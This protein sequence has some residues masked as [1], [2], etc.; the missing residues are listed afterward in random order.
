MAIE[1]TRI[2]KQVSQLLKNQQLIKPE[3]YDKLIKTIEHIALISGSREMKCCRDITSGYLHGDNGF[4]KDVAKAYP[5]LKKLAEAQDADPNDQMMMGLYAFQNPMCVQDEDPK[6]VSRKYLELAASKGQ[7]S[8]QF[9]V[10]LNFYDGLRGFERDY[11]KAVHYFNAFIKQETSLSQKEKAA[12]QLEFPRAKHMLALCTLNGYGCIKDEKLAIEMFSQLAMKE[13]F[14][15][16]YYELGKWFGSEKGGSNLKKAFVNYSLGAIKQDLK[17]KVMVA[18]CL[19]KGAGTEQNVDKGLSSLQELASQDAGAKNMLALHYLEGNYIPIDETL[20]FKLY[21]QNAMR[22]EGNAS[23]KACANVGRCYLFGIGVAKN[24]KQGLAYLEP[25]AKKGNT[26]AMMALG[27]YFKTHKA[28]DYALGAKYFQQAAE[29]GNEEGI[30]EYAYCLSKGMGVERDS[31]IAFELVQKLSDAGSLKAK[32]QLAQFYFNGIGT[33]RDMRIA[34][35]LFKEVINADHFGEYLSSWL[36]LMD[37]YEEGIGLDK[38][39]AKAKE[40]F[41][42]LEVLSKVNKKILPILGRCYETGVHVK[43]DPKK[44]FECYNLSATKK[45]NL[46]LGSLVNY[47]LHGIGTKNEKAAM[48][49]LKEATNKRDTLA[50]LGFGVCQMKGYGI[51]QNFVKGFHLFENLCQQTE[52]EHYNDAMNNLAWCLLYGLGT[53]KNE[54][55]AVKLFVRAS[56]VGLDVARK[57]LAWCYLQGLGVKQDIDFALSLFRVKSIAELAANQDPTLGLGLSMGD[58]SIPVEWVGHETQ[59]LPCTH[60]AWR[61]KKGIDVEKNMKLAAELYKKGAEKNDR[62]AAHNLALCY[63]EGLGVEKDLKKALEYY[64]IAAELQH[65]DAANNLA[66]LYEIGHNDLIKQDRKRAFELYKQAS[67]YKVDAIYNL[68]RCYEYGIGTEVSM[69]RAYDH[70]R[71]AADKGSEDAKDA[72]KRFA[73]QGFLANCNE[74]CPTCHN[75]TSSANTKQRSIE[76]NIISI[77]NTASVEQKTKKEAEKSISSSD[78]D[79]NAVTIDVKNDEAP[80]G[81]VYIWSLA[82]F[83][84]FASE[85]SDK[86][87]KDHIQEIAKLELSSDHKATEVKR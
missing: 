61:F 76:D 82:Q 24:E 17:C 40:I 57:N 46:F 1:R 74:S 43:E 22:P 67:L 7:K 31:K 86:F 79:A 59:S 71:F 53:D 2:F 60:L 44:A 25:L 37:G 58:N 35:S 18:D 12:M 52:I 48:Q 21:M 72:L 47:Y 8:A 66:T 45:V 20:A 64:T 51:E 33:R 3:L 9:I 80:D 26:D 16:A 13:N 5:F 34:M 49:Y 68:G 19:I 10:G 36:K 69:E 11:K 62:I 56:M 27:I 50:T 65:P 23:L 81:V 73:E 87:K 32:D 85:I 77:D 84:K 63:E 39:P 29:L 30:I 42:K 83:Q 54:A 78:V 4:K 15:D 6:A 41:A 38:D 14:P 28:S 70:Y 55:E 75:T